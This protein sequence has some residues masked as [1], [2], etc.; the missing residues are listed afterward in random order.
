M[1]VYTLWNALNIRRY[2]NDELPDL[3][4]EKSISYVE[5]IAEINIMTEQNGRNTE[6]DIFG[7]SCPKGGEPI[8]KQAYMGG[9]VYAWGCRALSG[10]CKK[11]RRRISLYGKREFARG[12][13]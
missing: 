12:R 11:K 10:N 1:R 8:L 3:E 9:R 5:L 6:K 13:K 7:K 4:N 2:G